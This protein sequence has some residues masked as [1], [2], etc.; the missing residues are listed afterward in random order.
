M[1]LRVVRGPS[2][3]GD[4]CGSGRVPSAYRSAFSPLE[5][6]SGN[7]LLSTAARPATGPKQLRGEG[8]L[9]N[10]LALSAAWLDCRTDDAATAAILHPGC[11]PYAMHGPTY[12]P[13]GNIRDFWKLQNYDH[14]SVQSKPCRSLE[15]WWDGRAMIHAQ[16][17]EA[18]EG[19]GYE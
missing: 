15:E 6:R 10:H 19:S 9:Q 18:G 14:L 12:P 16:N 7:Q 5:G 2:V 8:F 4:C 17:Q 1:R 3:V 13:L 11:S